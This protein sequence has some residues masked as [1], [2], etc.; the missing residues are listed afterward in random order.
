[1]FN[2]NVLIS[3]LN[4][5]TFAYQIVYDTVA[6]NFIGKLTEVAPATVTNTARYCIV[7]PTRALHTAG[8]IE[9]ETF[10]TSYLIALT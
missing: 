2:L 1:M 5:I 4:V 9:S 8:E 10:F 3:C 7:R 6:V